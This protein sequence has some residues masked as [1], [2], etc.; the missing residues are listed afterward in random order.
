MDTVYTKTKLIAH[1]NA[2]KPVG[3][4]LNSDLFY[5]K[6]ITN[7]IIY[8]RCRGQEHFP[9]SF[10]FSSILVR[11]RFTN[12]E[13]IFNQACT[14]T[15]NTVYQADD[16]DPTFSK[17]FSGNVI[18]QANFDSLYD[19]EVYDDQSFNVV[20]PLLEQMINAAIQW[21]NQND[22]LQNAYNNA[23]LLSFDARS[24]LYS[25]PFPAKYMIA[26]KLVGASDYSSYATTVIA[27]YNS[28][29]ETNKANFLQTL[30]NILDAL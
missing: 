20:R 7:A 22:T 16:D 23:E 15:N 12:V 14:A 8:I 17:G 21:A 26:K 28:R 6:A 2:I 24:D 25:Q 13:N 3:Y 19:N 18:G 10:I 4:T 5:E 1:L 27:S 9:H 29:G 30:K 11:I